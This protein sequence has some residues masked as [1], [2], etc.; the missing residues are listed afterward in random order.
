MEKKIKGIKEIRAIGNL[1]QNKQDL[2][3]SIGLL[4]SLL[5]RHLH[6]SV[7]RRLNE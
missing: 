7:F 1:H 5:P 2:S 3:S 4:I 6:A